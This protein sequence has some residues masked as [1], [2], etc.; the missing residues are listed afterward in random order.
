[1]LVLV[2]D[3]EFVDDLPAPL[4][5]ALTLDDQHCTFAIA[6][7]ASVLRGAYG[8]WSAGV[9]RSRTGIVFGPA[10]D[11]DGELL[12][13]SVPRRWPIPPRPG[14]GWLVSSGAST[15]VQLAVP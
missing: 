12:G 9:R 13:A 3:A 15:L 2:D 8:H 14:L 1:V 11:L 7:R 6:A 10:D 5:D 4:L